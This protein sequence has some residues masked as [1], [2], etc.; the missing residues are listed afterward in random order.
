MSL[1]EL[2]RSFFCRCP[3]LPEGVL[4]VNYLAPE[5]PAFGLTVVGG[6]VLK[7]YAD[8]GTL[9]F[10]DFVLAARTLSGGTVSQQ[11]AMAETFEK[12]AR[13]VEDAGKSPGL[14]LPDGRSLVELVPGGAFRLVD[15]TEKTARYE[16]SCRLI[17]QEG[18][19]KIE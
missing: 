6:G 8:G 16:L 4:S 1:I 11:Q 10:F 3:H 9:K 17:Y 14:C 7:R 15:E 18:G 5:P 2:A 19:E 12:V 13:W